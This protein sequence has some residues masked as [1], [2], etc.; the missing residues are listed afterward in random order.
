MIDYFFYKKQKKDKL[1]HLSSLSE[2]STEILLVMVSERNLDLN[3]KAR[4]GNFVE[5]MNPVH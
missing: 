5:G 4:D 1:K 3:K 2:K